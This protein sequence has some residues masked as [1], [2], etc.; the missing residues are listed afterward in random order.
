[1]TPEQYTVMAQQSKYVEYMH[2]YREYYSYM[3]WAEK[4][5]SAETNR[6]YRMAQQRYADEAAAHYA[7]AAARLKM[8]Q[9]WAQ[10][11]I[12]GV[13]RESH[14]KQKRNPEEA[15]TAALRLYS[16]ANQEEKAMLHHVS[17]GE[18]KCL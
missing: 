18:R 1:M 2:N 11:Q 12:A 9:H 8:Y 17:G 7:T 6:V 14:I 5:H 16:Q 13:S 15:A 4:Q 10:E 3:Q